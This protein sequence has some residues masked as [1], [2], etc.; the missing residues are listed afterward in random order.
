MCYNG[1]V[2]ICIFIGAYL[3]SFL[4]QW[5]TLSHGRSPTSAA[6]EATVCCG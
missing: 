6:T 4:F 1:Y 5:E 3:G 2:I